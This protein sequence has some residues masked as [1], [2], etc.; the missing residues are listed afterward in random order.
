LGLSG[1]I[2]AANYYLIIPVA[3]SRSRYVKVKIGIYRGGIG[4]IQI[5]IINPKKNDVPANTIRA[6]SSVKT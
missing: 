1:K 6:F 5:N 2:T 4:A 3:A